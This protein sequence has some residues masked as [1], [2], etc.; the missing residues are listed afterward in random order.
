MNCEPA[1]AVMSARF[2]RLAK[3]LWMAAREAEAERKQTFLPGGCVLYG[4]LDGEEGDCV[5]IYMLQR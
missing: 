3:E 4:R 2:S 5:S 1:L